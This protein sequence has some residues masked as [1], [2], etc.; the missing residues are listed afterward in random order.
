MQDAAEDASEPMAA[1]GNPVDIAA[2]I[3]RWSEGGV[4][5]DTVAALQAGETALYRA[6]DGATATFAEQFQ[7]VQVD[8]VKTVGRCMA[9]LPLCRRRNT[10]GDDREPVSFA[11]KR[12]DAGSLRQAR[13]LP[14]GEQRVF[15]ARG[16]GD[17]PAPVPFDAPKLVPGQRLA[18][19]AVD[20]EQQHAGAIAGERIDPPVGIDGRQHCEIG[21]RC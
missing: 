15:D 16:T 8:P 18:L 13:L 12:K 19:G 7:W 6:L 21:Q 20:V 1:S 9:D 10:A 14:G 17:E 3:G 5:N 4:E 2:T 11:G